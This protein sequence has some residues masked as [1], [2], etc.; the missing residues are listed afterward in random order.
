MEERLDEATVK[1]GLRT[2]PLRK[3]VEVAS[4][5][6]EL[7]ELACAVLAQRPLGSLSRK[8]R[9][10]STRTDCG[11]QREVG[12]QAEVGLT[13]AASRWTAP[14]PDARDH[15]PPI[16]VSMVRLHVPARCH[17]LHHHAARTRTSA[18]RP[19]RMPAAT[20][21]PMR[22]TQIVARVAWLLC[23]PGGGARGPSI[24]SMRAG[25]GVNR[26]DDGGPPVR[27]ERCSAQFLPRGAPVPCARARA[28]LARQAAPAD[29][30]LTAH[31]CGPPHAGWDHRPGDRLGS[32]CGSRLR[33]SAARG[34]VA[35][36]AATPVAALGH[37]GVGAMATELYHVSVEAPI[38]TDSDRSSG[39]LPLPRYDLGS[40][41]T[42]IEAGSLSGQPGSLL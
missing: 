19:F 33:W 22:V 31:R 36:K 13:S 7:W 30:S 9:P 24:S 32:R 26:S 14:R 38:D 29:P 18:Q 11:V 16:A 10:P 40:T 35:A 6:E 39:T 34:L 28:G 5:P 25:G 42:R 3:R 4:Q 37:P 12:D 2:R 20:T 21:P 8:D 41:V 1:R 17:A 27:S 15:R 23:T